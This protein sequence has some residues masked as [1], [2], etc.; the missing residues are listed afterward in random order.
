LISHYAKIQKKS[1][2]LSKFIQGKLNGAPTPSKPFDNNSSL[3]KQLEMVTKL[4]AIRNDLDNNTKRQIFFVGFGGW[5]THKDQNERHPKLLRQLSKSLSTFY[6][7]LEELD[8]TNQITIFTASEFGRTLTPNSSG[9]GHGWGGH[10]LVMGG[11]VNGGDIFGKMPKLQTD[12]PDAIEDRGRIIPTI[13]V[14]QYSATLASWF[15]LSEQQI[16]TIFPILNLFEVV[17]TL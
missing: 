11:S 7:A 14:E 3:A 6:L 4:I 1:N 15:G 13:S 17:V 12:S 2:D 16:N 5:D 8:V 9:T 10:N